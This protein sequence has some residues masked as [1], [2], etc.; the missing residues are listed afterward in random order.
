MPFIVV[1]LQKDDQAFGGLYSRTRK[2]CNRGKPGSWKELVENVL[3]NGIWVLLGHNCPSS[4]MT[5][6]MNADAGGSKAT[7]LR[8]AHP[9]R[10]SRNRVERVGSCCI[11]CQWPAQTLC[12]SRREQRRCHPAR[13]RSL[14]QAHCARPHMERNSPVHRPR[15]VHEVCSLPVYSLFAYMFVVVNAKYGLPA[16]F[17]RNSSWLQSHGQRSN[18]VPG[19]N[20]S[21]LISTLMYPETRSGA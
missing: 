3:G 13:R 11:R 12:F 17:N 1:F 20:T 19:I 15:E 10:I 16:N 8:H 6:G 21:S 2:R 18:R 9:P 5:Q 7:T 14:R 4:K